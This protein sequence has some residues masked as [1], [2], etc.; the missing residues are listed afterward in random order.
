MSATAISRDT[1]GSASS[2]VRAGA[3]GLIAGLVFAMSAMIVGIFT[4]N[5]WAPP[6]GIGQ[7]LG[8][9]Q[10]GHDFQI[11]PFIVGL[12]GHMMNSIIFGLVFLAVAVALKLRGIAAVV[13]GMMYG[14]VVYAVMNWVV[15]R[16]LLSGT[17]GSF[18][19]ANPEWSWVVA[20]LMFGGALGL[21][22]AYRPLRRRRVSRDAEGHLERC[23]HRRERS[24]R[25]SRRQPLFP[26]GKHPAGIPRRKRDAHP[27]SVEGRGQLL[28]HRGRRQDEPG[29][30]L[31]LSDALR[32]GR[33]DQGPHRVLA[34]RQGHALTPAG[35]QSVYRPERSR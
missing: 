30:R 13:V 5:L 22:F 19:G 28:Q 10:Q 24:H 32:G 29:W 1:G 6:Q 2:A 27:L 21:L 11:V 23:G 17:S 3:A 18:L 25:Q 9:G 4:S 26:G 8:I 34:R 35:S 16:N 33:P 31:V 12:M 20:H 7:A 15:L 14:I